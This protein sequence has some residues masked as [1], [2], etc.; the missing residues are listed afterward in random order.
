M[1]HFVRSIQVVEIVLPLAACSGWVRVELSVFQSSRVTCLDASLGYGS[2]FGTI[3]EALNTG[4]Y[5]RDT[6][7]VNGS[8]TGSEFGA[9]LGVLLIAKGELREHGGR[10]PQSILNHLTLSIV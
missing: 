6:D 4:Q 1:F 3:H 7:A 2:T 10:E 9:V 8:V 5:F